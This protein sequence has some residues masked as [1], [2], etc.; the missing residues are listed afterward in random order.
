[1]KIKK[2]HKLFLTCSRIATDTRKIEANSMFF[3]LKGANFDA[4]TFA[5]QAFFAYNF[6]Y[7]MFKGKVA[8]QNPWK[9]NTLEWT[10][11]IKP[12]HGNWEGDIPPVYRWPYDYSKPGAPDDFIPQ[13]IPFSATPESNLPEE[14]AEIAKE[15][16]ISGLLEAQNDS[17]NR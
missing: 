17:Y 4:N 7:S 11:P 3:A 6:F 12:A 16:E 2:L 13:N 14:T 5:S 9:S 15:N 8:P 1:M 10:T